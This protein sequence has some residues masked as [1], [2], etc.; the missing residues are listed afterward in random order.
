MSGGI[1]YRYTYDTLGRLIGSTMKSGSTVALQTQHKYD[2]SNRLSK[3]VWALPGKTYQEGYEYDAD[4]GRLTKKR[5]TLPTNET[6]NIT[7]GYDNLSR[8]SSVTTS[9]ATTHY[10]YAGAFYGGGTTCNVSE[11]TTTSVHTGSGV[12]APLHLRYTYDAMG[13]ILTENRLNPDGSTAESLTYTYDNQFQLTGAV[14]SVNGAWNYRYDTYGNLRG[15]DHGSDRVSYT[16]G[17]ANWLDL[18][19]AVSGTKNGTSFSGSYTY[20]GAG[21]PTSFFNVGDLSTWTMT[22]RNGRELATASNGTHSVSY[23]YDVN[24]LRTYKIVDGVRHDYVYASGQLL[25]ES[26]T[27]DGHSYVYDFLY[28]QS[29]RPSMLNYISNGYSSRYYYVLNLQG[30]VMALVTSEG[31]E[32]AKYTYDAWGNVTP[33]TTLWLSNRNPLRYRGYYYDTETGF[34]YL[35]SRYYD[36]ALGRFLNADSYASTGQGFLGYNMFAYCGNNP[37]IYTDHNGKKPIIPQEIIDAAKELVETVLGIMYYATSRNSKG[38]LYEYWLN[39]EKE[40]KWIRHNSNHGNPK[41]HDKPHDH[42]VIKDD[43]NNDTLGPSQPQN[44]GFQAPTS[45]NKQSNNENDSVVR[46]VATAGAIAV[47][48]FAVYEIGKW[49]IAVLTAPCTGGGSIIVAGCMP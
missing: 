6:A 23:D 42:K 18:L 34:Y 11:L 13:N 37:V 5:I 43:D 30:D 39:F 12:F 20:D 10:A 38:E 9:A 26:F 41:R 32:V 48:G 29:G 21:N 15:K 47:G 2:D 49:A 28:D 36:P 22:W 1:V 33:D 31:V 44:P 27:L 17:D 24:G 19:T 4:N 7:L 3:Q 46:Q 35:Q 45:N 25:R 16:Y 40:V 8:V 14:S